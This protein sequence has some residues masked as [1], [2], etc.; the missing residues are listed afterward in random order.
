MILVYITLIVVFSFFLIKSS[1]QLV[2][3]TRRISRELKTK[4]FI[5][6]ALLL[7]VGT[8]LP[9]LFVGITSALE[10][11]PELSLGVILGSNISNIALIGALSAF[12]F[13]QI[14]I[15]GNYLKKDLILAFLAGILPFALLADGVL[16]RV[17]GLLLLSVYFVYSLS[18]F[19]ERYEKISQEHRNEGFVYRFLREFSPVDVVKKKEIARFFISLTLLLFSSDILV[20]VSKSLAISLGIP[21]FLIGLIL[22]AIGTSLPELVFSIKSLYGHQIS[23]FF[24]N[25]LGSTVAN[26]TLIIGI[27][28]FISPIFVEDGKRYLTIA[29]AFAVVF[30]LFIFFVESKKRL[31]RWESALLLLFYLVFLL[32]EIL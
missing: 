13:G 14:Q 3:A 16:S 24:G 30:T 10:G 27:T 20:K 15:V 17:D 23:M 4:T 11:A 2:I 9:E 19:K 31:D 18:L 7:A 25:I 26:S 32:I 8:S 21:I 5:V 6:S 28:A 29:G 1:E 12:I 22:I